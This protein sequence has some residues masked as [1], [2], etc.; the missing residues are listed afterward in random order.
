MSD[1]ENKTVRQSNGRFQKKAPKE[2]I[3][4]GSGIVPPAPTTVLSDDL[5]AKAL[6][7]DASAA[8]IEPA[9]KADSSYSSAFVSSLPEAK[10]DMVEPGKEPDVAPVVGQPLPKEEKPAPVV[11][12]KPVQASISEPEPSKEPQPVKEEK[13]VAPEV[14]SAPA[15]APVASAPQA[16]TM[17]LLKSDRLEKEA[18]MAV[19]PASVPAPAVEEERARPVDKSWSAP[20][21]SFDGKPWQVF[22]NLIVNSLLLLLT[23]GIAFPWVYC[24][25]LR[26]ESDHMIYD[27]KRMRF[28]GRGAQLI[29]HWILW[30][31]LSLIT[32]TIFAW[33]IPIKLQK[34]KVKHCHFE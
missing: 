31:F 21:S 12:Q 22:V 10:K 11:G 32:L 34:W 1:I 14:V 27:G 29:G 30:Y 20:Q 16:P 5:I 9:Q 17:Q 7:S 33:W 13:P 6:A 15:P 4:A 3:G 26:W 2:T 25:N 19:T 23:L 24:R 18:A 8:P 28:D